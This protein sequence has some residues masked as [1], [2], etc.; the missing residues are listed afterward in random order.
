MTPAARDGPGQ[1][2][3]RGPNEAS[4]GGAD[5]GTDAVD[6]V[7]E[8]AARF[9]ASLTAHPSDGEGVRTPVPGGDPGG[10]TLLLPTPIGG[11]MT[12]WS[13]AVG[14]VGGPPSD[15]PV[16]AAAARILNALGAPSRSLAPLPLGPR[17]GG[18]RPVRVL[19]LDGGGVRG[20]VEIGIL[21][22]ILATAQAAWP[23]PLPDGSPPVHLCD[24]FDLVVGTST[25]GI[26]A[27]GIA[28]GLS[29]DDLERVYRETATVIFKAESY[30]NLLRNYGPGATSARAMEAVLR[31]R[32]GPAADAPLTSVAWGPTRRQRGLPRPHL[33]LVSQLASRAPCATF[34]LRSYG[35]A[36]APQA[37][38][39][40][41]S[42]SLAGGGSPVWA[43]S[44]LAGDSGLSLLDS[45]RATSAA[46]WYM[47][48][49][50]VAKDLRTGDV[51]SPGTGPPPEGAITAQLRL[52]DGGIVCNNPADVAIHEARL[53]YG[54]ERPLVLVS[55]GTGCGVAAEAPGAGGYLPTWLQTLVNAIGDVHQTDAT[56]AHLLGS[57][58]TY[59]RFNPVGDA[60]GVSLDDARDESLQ[61]LASAAQAYA[62]SRAHD[63]AHVV[64]NLV[65]R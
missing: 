12:T 26:I 59:W 31:A 45:L 21:R 32:L 30:T 16:R 1:G 28:N 7:R 3:S 10:G 38:G 18:V 17:G 53:L 65:P 20:L 15:D 51:Y 57:G 5:G 46:P 9:L 43:T 42:A 36:S 14:G 19:S 29:L 34:L 58:D 50:Q 27:A 6:P 41:A 2:A 64:S 60:F 39:G 48:E 62:D 61:A 55:C 47:E 63:I 25:G 35:Y 54:R 8:A 44:R 52:I 37:G 23:H 33:C 24:L 40:G 49:V 11:P 22:T 13:P 56:V 4:P